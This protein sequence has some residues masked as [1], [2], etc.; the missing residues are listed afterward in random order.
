MRHAPNV[1]S[2]G[3]W[4]DD[5]TASGA[6]IASAVI[7]PTTTKGLAA[8]F[9]MS[10][11]FANNRLGIVRGHGHSFYNR[12]ILYFVQYIEVQYIDRVASL[13]AWTCETCSPQI[14][15]VCGMRRGSRKT[16]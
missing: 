11:R 13:L 4:S 12:S 8:S 9:G 7:M 16:I 3:H 10:P 2:I 6:A 1:L 15:V 5:P 14:C